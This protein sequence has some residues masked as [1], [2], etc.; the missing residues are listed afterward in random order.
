M[1]LYRKDSGSSLYQPLHSRTSTRLFGLQSGTIHDE[2]NGELYEV[3]LTSATPSYEALSYAWG[4]STGTHDI[5]IKGQV[6]RIRD[7]LYEALRHLRYPDKNRMLWIDAI[8]ISQANLAEKAEQVAMIGTIFGG[9]ARV[10][11]WVG[12]HADFSQYIFDD[13][14][15]HHLDK[16]AAFEQKSARLQIGASGCDESGPRDPGVH[17]VD[18]WRL[19][20]VV[21][22]PFFMRD[23]WKRYWIVQEITLARHIIIQ[24]GNSSLSWNSLFKDHWYEHEGQH[25]WDGIPI[26]TNSFHWDGELALDYDDILSY[27]N[28]RARF[29]GGDKETTLPKAPHSLEAVPAARQRGNDIF[30]FLYRLCGLQCEDRRDRVFAALSLLQLPH[31]GALR[32]IRPD[33]N[34]T[35][36]ELAV[37]LIQWTIELGTETG[38]LLA[39]IYVPEILHFDVQEYVPT[40]ALLLRRAQQHDPLAPIWH[41]IAIRF[42]L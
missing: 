4:A 6:V 33:Y 22:A 26:L 19:R 30:D 10:V 27:R 42:L 9:A 31:R 15:W 37:N 25:T 12:E 16:E 14:E 38:P 20:A 18:V 32:T 21:W 3:E 23:F 1:K 24:C 35:I 36:P 2:I 17:A 28:A 8:S 40:F 41:K 13:V 34:L 5:R 39:S 11:A 7:N 29:K